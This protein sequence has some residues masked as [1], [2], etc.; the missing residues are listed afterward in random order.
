M[1]KGRRE[2]FTDGVIAINLPLLLGWRWCRL[3][4][5]GV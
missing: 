4:S 1:T 5:V 3:L 2:G